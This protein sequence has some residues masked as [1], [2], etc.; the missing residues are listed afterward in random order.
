MVM[1]K[2]EWTGRWITPCE[3]MGDICPV[4]RKKWTA[5]KNITRAVAYLTALGVYEAS[6]NGKPVGEEVLSPGWTVYRKRLQY[7]EYDIT[8]LLQE[9]NCLTV[10]VGRGWFRS[11]MPGWMDFEEKTLRYNQKAALL[12]EI[13]LYYEDGTKRILSSDE[14]WE[15][16]ESPVR[17]SEIYDGEHY[18]ATF[19]PAYSLRAKILKWPYDILIPQEGEKIL[20][21]ERIKAKRIF[22]TPAGETVVDFGQEVTGYVEF[23]LE[24]RKGEEVRFLHGEVLD[25]K[26][27]FYNEN[28]RSA[29]AEIIYICRD[30][31]QSWHP[32]LTFFGF[33]YLKLEAYP[34]HPKPEQFTAIAVHSDMRRTGNFRCGLEL[35]NQLYSNIIWG[36]KGNFLDVP[37][38]CPQR[39][40][41]LGWTGDA[42]VFVKAASYNYDV[43]RFFRK[44]LR[45]LK[46]DQR[47]DGA[48]GQVIPDY[49]AHEQPSAAWGD[50]AVI[51]P[52]QIY[53]TYGNEEVLKE[54]FS[55][56]KAWVDYITA[57]TAS[58]G[59]WT[60]G[61]HFG[62]WLGL[63]AAPGSYKGASREDFIA[64]AF[65]I[66]STELLIKAGHILG[67]DINFYEQLLQK[68]R[69]TFQETFTDC[70]TQTEYILAIWFSLTEQPQKAADDLAT[71][72]LADGC[73]MRTGFVGTPYLLHV[74][75]KYGYTELAY[76]LLLREE[77]PSWLYSVKKGATTVWEHWDGIMEN[78]EFWSKD[79]NS[80]NH[81]AYGAVAD[82]LYEQAAGIQIPEG[83]PG[84]S[85]VLI[86]PKPDQRLGWL[87]ASIQTRNGLVKSSWKYQENKIRYEIHVDM[88]AEIRIAEQ[89][90]QAEPGDYIFWS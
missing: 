61:V 43:E 32:H 15:C 16:A 19:T 51:C 11:P 71:M 21:Q 80:F 57:S 5:Q 29:K 88:P 58:E 39:D 53:Q 85:K 22:V 31:R 54:Q 78:G 30:G 33:R 14:T 2:F 24:A 27:N 8:K 55:S 67:E 17:F 84:F 79:M 37:T 72:I 60:G 56:M 4:F 69:K 25:S 52:W 76:T 42:Q 90:W 34:T 26:G 41:R 18:D 82:W 50:A 64:S 46:A 73:R 12:A 3:D 87:E 20:E 68:L 10:T 65:Y 7:Q 66:H 28:Y 23:S 48:V 74:L 77:Y 81:Y 83:H 63:D 49:I 6:L 36:Q 89:C 13:H 75:S 62:D 9:E 40:E 45:D 1:Q 47:P 35:V 86:E 38:D 70:R 44:W 59:L